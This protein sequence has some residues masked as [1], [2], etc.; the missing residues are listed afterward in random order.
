MGENVKLPYF[1][2]KPFPLVHKMEE[3]L[4]MFWTLE[5]SKKLVSGETKKGNMVGGQSLEYLSPKFW[6]KIVDYCTHFQ[7][8]CFEKNCNFLNPS[9]TQFNKKNIWKNLMAFFLP[10]LHTGKNFRSLGKNK[11][12][13]FLSFNFTTTIVG[14]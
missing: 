13:F 2:W 8:D 1:P 9:I 7:L 4:W 11:N 10:L 6:I 5:I 3:S 12:I 14:F